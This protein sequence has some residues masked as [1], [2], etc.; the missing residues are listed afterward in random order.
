MKQQQFPS[1]SYSPARKRPPRFAEAKA[2]ANV[3]FLQVCQAATNRAMKW[4][5]RAGVHPLETGQTT[6][7]LAILRCRS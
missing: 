4:L 2:A 3:F 7:T 1:Y 5:S 6:L